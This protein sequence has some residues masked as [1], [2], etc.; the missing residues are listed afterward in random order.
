MHLSTQI[1]L[2]APRTRKAEHYVSFERK[3]EGEHCEPG[4]RKIFVRKFIRDRVLAGA[5]KVSR[6]FTLI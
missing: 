1:V 2:R 6:L 3:R 5:Q 4:S